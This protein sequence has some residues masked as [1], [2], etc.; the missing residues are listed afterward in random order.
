MQHYLIVFLGAGLG[1]AFRHAANLAAT[2]L[3]PTV[4]GISTLIVNVLGSF[5]MGV[6]IEYLAT[7]G[8]ASQN[9]RLF[10]ATGIL[11]GFTTFSAFS[12][13][14]AL[15]MERGQFGWAAA[16]VI[17]SVLLSIAALFAGLWIMRQA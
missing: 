14:T 12:L 1:G 4:I 2:R 10:A 3:F 13:E 17:A 7:K 9:W 8:G 16:N 15:L 6:L 11:G 5:L